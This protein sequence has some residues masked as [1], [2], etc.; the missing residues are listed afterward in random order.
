MVHAN[1][2]ISVDLQI[3]VRVIWDRFMDFRYGPAVL[4]I[5][6]LYNFSGD[7][8]APSI[9]ARMPITLAKAWINFRM[10]SIKLKRIPIVDESFYV[11]GILWVRIQNTGVSSRLNISDLTEMV[12]PPCHTL[13]Q[14]YVCNGELSSQLYQRSG[15]VVSVSPP[16]VQRIVYLF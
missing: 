4:R 13:V 10:L 7:I 15:D 1:F 8:T 3:D 16:F 6:I 2:W 11:L 5:L 12:L 9:V 14:F